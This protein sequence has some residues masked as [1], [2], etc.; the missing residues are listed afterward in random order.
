MRTAGASDPNLKAVKPPD[1]LAAAPAPPSPNCM[2]LTSAAAV[3][4]ADASAGVTTN[5]AAGQADSAADVEV[6]D[7]A[8]CVPSAGAGGSALGR[9]AVPAHR[10][11]CR[12]CDDASQHLLGVSAIVH[13]QPS[14][15][16]DMLLVIAR[17]GLRCLNTDVRTGIR[18]A[19][20]PSAK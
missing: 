1:E 17:C 10:P 3:E 11:R 7:G 12:Q 14:C 8:H 5:V 9:A 2:P 13:Q 6:V 4:A 18:D 15:G 20:G 19:A 16:V